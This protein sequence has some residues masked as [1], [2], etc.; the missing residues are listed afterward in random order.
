MALISTPSHGQEENSLANYCKDSYQSYLSLMHSIV[1]SS[2]ADNP[3]EWHEFPITSLK[4]DQK[5]G[6]VALW[7]GAKKAKNV[8]IRVS[9]SHGIDGFI[10]AAGQLCSL[11][12]ARY[13]PAGLACVEIV[14][15]NVEGFAH[16]QRIFNS[17]LTKKS[18]SLSELPDAPPSALEQGKRRHSF[19]LPIKKKNKTYLYTSQFKKLFKD[20]KEGMR[21][22]FSPISIDKL[23]PSKKALFQWL[24]EKLLA[25]EAQRV[26]CIDSYSN[27]GLFGRDRLCF[28][29][30]DGTEPE[31]LFPLAN[32]VKVVRKYGSEAPTGN[33]CEIL[34]RVLKNVTPAIQFI[35][36]EQIFETYPKNE[37]IEILSHYEEM[38]DSGK[39]LKKCKQ[40]LLEC[41]Y[42]QK[43]EWRV[44]SIER[45]QA[46]FAQ[47][48][49]FMRQS[50]M[51]QK[52]VYPLKELVLPELKAN[53][54]Q[55]SLS[56]RSK[57]IEAAEGLYGL[58]MRTTE[59]VLNRDEA[60]RQF[61]LPEEIW[62]QIRQSWRE[63]AKNMILG[64]FD[65][66]LSE[67]G[68][69]L[70][71]FNLGLTAYFY[72]TP[73]LQSAWAKEN[74]YTNS[75]EPAENLYKMLLSDPNESRQHA[76]MIRA[77]RAAGFRFVTKLEKG[78]RV[79]QVLSPNETDLTIK[80]LQKELKTPS[81]E[82]IN[83]PLWMLIAG[84]K[85]LLP[86]MYRRFPN[87]PYLL[88]SEFEVVDSL[89]ENGYVTKPFGGSH[90][91]NIEIVGKDALLTKF[92]KGRFYKEL[93]IFQEY[94][95]SQTAKGDHL[96]PSIFTVD[97]TYAGI[98]MRIAED[99][100]LTK[101]N[102]QLVPLRIVNDPA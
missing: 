81:K 16:L 94:S 64:R 86:F 69:K 31:L 96:E 97:G 66:S 44:N 83:A 63:Q 48:Q 52:N 72:A 13:M 82:Y 80:Q 58:V 45:Q 75:L 95:P 3:L 39:D 100:I 99:P 53:C 70:Y 40:E 5:L 55:L 36:M 25:A 68:I 89:V 19:S 37:V 101:E 73:I 41:F 26:V 42:P 4:N 17:Q 15:Y 6:I 28:L 91:E 50:D 18:A 38:Q 93:R 12:T 62:P 84:S 88:R 65:F 1:A 71:E 49:E 30:Y 47:A 9:G 59:Y 85:A 67:K 51:L 87:N 24:G 23:H 54:C 29:N 61:D 60:L 78:L 2:T 98:C 92:T 11:E 102:S 43:K 74:G 77:M 22:E 79:R 10:G 32:R 90:G 46:L 21:T 27:P 76:L 8:I 34:Y 57:L 33:F 56:T 35:A 20:E 14:G 7:R